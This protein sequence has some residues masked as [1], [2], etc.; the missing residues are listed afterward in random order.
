MKIPRDIRLV[1]NDFFNFRLPLD[2]PTQKHV[3]TRKP[4]PEELLDYALELRH[5]LDDFLM[6]E[7]FVRVTMSYSDD[8]IEAVVEVIGDG[9]PFPIDAGSVKQGNKTRTSILTELADTL[10]K[11]V[12]QWVYIQRGLRFFDGPRI[13]IY[14]TR[15][16]IHWTRTRARIDAGDIIGELIQGHDH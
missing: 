16:I 11:Q 12:S 7:S 6:G 10:R 15:R 3:A 2:T 8:L 5:K 4:T 14:K 13:H 9:G 1:I